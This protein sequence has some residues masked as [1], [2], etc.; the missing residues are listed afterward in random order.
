MR[1]APLEGFGRVCLNEYSQNT[2][3][4][5]LFINLVWLKHKTSNIVKIYEMQWKH[6]LKSKGK[7]RKDTCIMHTDWKTDSLKQYKQWLL[8][9]PHGP[10]VF[11]LKG[12]I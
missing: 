9:R 8:D 12:E 11:T 1:L 6:I 3:T 4:T 7:K 5:D 2:K 10:M